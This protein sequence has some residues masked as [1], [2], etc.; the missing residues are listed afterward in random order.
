MCYAL[1][2]DD[3][4]RREPDLFDPTSVPSDLRPVLSK[5]MQSN[6]DQR[7]RNA[8]EFRAALA[9]PG[10]APPRPEPRGG[11]KGWATW[12]DPAGRRYFHAFVNKI[13]NKSITSASK[14]IT[15]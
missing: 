12:V 13:V 8:A 4:Q 1:T 2:Y 6:P 14:M 9:A 5:A 7:Y 10:P 15:Y 11:S 3:P